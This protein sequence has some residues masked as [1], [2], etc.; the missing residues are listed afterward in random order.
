MNNESKTN[1]QTK[2]ENMLPNERYCKKNQRLY[3]QAIRR[4]SEFSERK[5]NT[6]NKYSRLDMKIEILKLLL[7]KI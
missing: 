1:E 3:R 4:K 7:A 5:M 6:S 2:Q